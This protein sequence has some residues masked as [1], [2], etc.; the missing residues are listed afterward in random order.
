MAQIA[1]MHVDVDHGSAFRTAT[2]GTFSGLGAS[3]VNASTR[4]HLQV[5]GQNIGS[6]CGTPLGALP[7]GGK[8]L[9][10]GARPEAG[11]CLSYCLR[12]SGPAALCLSD[13]GAVV[14]AVVARTVQVP[15]DKERTRR[16]PVRR[17]MAVLAGV[18]DADPVA[19]TPSRSPGGE[20]ALR[21]ANHRCVML[22][23]VAWAVQVH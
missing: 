12:A 1:E 11:A 13:Y 23:E 19:I 15:R 14:T 6:A 5:A 8:L 17:L 18:V 22:G 7:A 21:L 9:S 20:G 3:D 4:R 16:A 10:M 2:A